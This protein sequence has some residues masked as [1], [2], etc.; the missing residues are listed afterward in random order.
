MLRSLPKPK[1]NPYLRAFRAWWQHDRLLAL[2]AFVLI[3]LLVLA[4]LVVSA[5]NG[6]AR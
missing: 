6:G 5:I 1:A 2:S 3:V 4:M